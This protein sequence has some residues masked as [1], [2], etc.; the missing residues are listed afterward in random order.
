MCD[1]WTRW[2]AL[3]T[4]LSAVAEFGLRLSAL[5]PR[6]RSC[7]WREWPRLLWQTMLDDRIYLMG[8]WSRY[9]PHKDKGDDHDD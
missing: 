1:A 3:L 7:K 6:L 4:M 9:Q 8:P 2:L 5:Q